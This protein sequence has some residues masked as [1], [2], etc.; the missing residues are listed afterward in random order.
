MPPKA[1]PPPKGKPKED[2]SPPPRKAP[3]GEEGTTSPEFETPTGSAGNSGTS[4]PRT[5]PLTTY[6]DL[7]SRFNQLNETIANCV[8]GKSSTRG[9]LC[10]CQVLY[11]TIVMPL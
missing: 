5:V 3:S 8:I 1:P 9:R 10:R 2:T 7:V 4:T 11:P 6:N